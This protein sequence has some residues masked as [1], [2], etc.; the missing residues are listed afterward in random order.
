MARFKY[1]DCELYLST[2]DHARLS[3]A[4]RPYSG[5]PALDNVLEH[6]LLKAAD[7]TEYGTLL[8]KALFPPADEELLAGYRKALAIASQAGKRLRFRLHIAATAPAW[9][10]KLQWEFLYDP[11]KHLALGHSREIAFSRSLSGPSGPDEPAE[12]PRLLVVLSCPRDQTE[13]GLA[14]IDEQE[15]LPALDRALRPLEASV[16]WEF[17]GC[18]N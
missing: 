13:Y 12:K 16:T 15:I 6:E 5:R 3:V 8:F 1:L 17:L 4:D 10:H 7:P 11:R 2:P 18:K 9:L 14:M